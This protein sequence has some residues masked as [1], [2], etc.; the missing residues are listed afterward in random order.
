LGEGKLLGALL[1]EGLSSLIPVYG[2]LHIVNGFLPG[3]ALGVFPRHS[4]VG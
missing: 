4:D 2:I 3:G 1:M